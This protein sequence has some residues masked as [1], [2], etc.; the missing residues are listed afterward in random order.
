MR[1]SFQFRHIDNGGQHEWLDTSMKTPENKQICINS[2]QTETK[3]ICLHLRW[4][5]KNTLL[6]RAFEH[7]WKLLYTRYYYYYYHY[8]LSWGYCFQPVM[9]II[10]VNML[11]NMPLHFWFWLSFF[12]PK[13]HMAFI[14]YHMWSCSSI[15]WLTSVS[16]TESAGQQFRKAVTTWYFR[17]SFENANHL[18]LFYLFYLFL[19]RYFPS[20]N[21]YLSFIGIGILLLSA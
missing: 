2:K 16:W 18:M 21:I 5:W 1:I 4:N 17:Q 20:N 19:C 12:A 8:L 11:Q 9:L 14:T 15:V 13:Y 3:Q 6:S 7:S 10:V